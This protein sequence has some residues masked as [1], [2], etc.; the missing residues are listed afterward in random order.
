MSS[1]SGWEDAQTLPLFS[2]A[3]WLDRAAVI[4][5]D[6]TWTWREIHAASLALSDRLMDSQIICNLCTSHLACLIVWLASTRRELQQILPASRGNLDLISTLTASLKPTLIVSDDTLGHATPLAHVKNLFFQPQVRRNPY[7]DEQLSWSPKANVPL[8]TLYTSGSTGAPEAHHKSL[9]QLVDGAR[10]LGAGLNREFGAGLRQPESVTQNLLNHLAWLVSSVPLQH[11]F[12]IE[13]SL[14]LSVVYGN[15]VLNQRPLL[16]ADIQSA[17]A[18]CPEHSIWIATPL[19]LSALVRSETPVKNCSLVLASTMPL[20][21][22]LAAKAECFVAAPVIEIYGSTETGALATRRT[23][24]ADEWLLLDGVDI[25]G[26]PQRLSVVGKHF[27]SPQ[28]LTDLI[29]PTS[30]TTFKLLGRAKDL[31]KIAGRRTSVS[32]LNQI[33]QRLAGL[34][35]AAFYLPSATEFGKRLALIYVSHTL[36]QEDIRAYLRKKID[37]IFIPRVFIKVECIARSE[38][39]KLTDHILASIHADWFAKKKPEVISFAFSVSSK[40]PSLAGHFPDNPVVPG[41]VILEKILAGLIVCVGYRSSYF[42]QIKF[43]SILCPDQLA[44]IS[45]QIKADKCVF[46]VS[47]KRDNSK[48]VVARGTLMIDLTQAR[49]EM[50]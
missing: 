13:A 4:A 44:N 32:T 48:I 26:E 15:P 19:H 49:H 36:S 27:T 6:H 16:P 20:S 18:I 43:E 3:Q 41:V 2:H 37:P 24:I 22:E 5:K 40:H 47:A 8:F 45:Y 46:E 38:T 30:G 29:A 10:I 21:T 31:I 50:D 23:A 25:F 1:A 33:L 39:G 7:S 28:I 12:G 17:L 42:R 14:M 35:D 34:D 9:G 11:M